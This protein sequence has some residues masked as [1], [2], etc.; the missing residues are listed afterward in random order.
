MDEV[1]QRSCVFM[2]LLNSEKAYVRL[3]QAIHGVYY[4]PL[5]AALDSNRAIISSANLVMLFNPMLDI[6][7]A[8]K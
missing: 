4:N 5:R 6:L 7:E 3:L 2:E 1:D 8:N